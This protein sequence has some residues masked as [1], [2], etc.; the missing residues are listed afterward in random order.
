MWVFV[1]WFYLDLFWPRKHN[2]GGHRTVESEDADHI[3]HEEWVLRTNIWG[4]NGGVL[5]VI[6][7]RPIIS[8]LGRSH[9]G[10]H[11]TFLIILMTWWI[12]SCAIMRVSPANHIWPFTQHRYWPLTQDEAR[13][14]ILTQ[15]KKHFY[16]TPG[17]FDKYFSPIHLQYWSICHWR[18]YSDVLR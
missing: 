11:F 10:L 8:I 16:G 13:Y 3:S 5:M 15:N 9:G 12:Q 18:Q 1:C 7:T 14:H 17:Q 6:D 2:I 4:M